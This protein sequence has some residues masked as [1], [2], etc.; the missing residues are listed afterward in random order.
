MEIKTDL[1]AVFENYCDRYNNILQHYYPAHNSTGFTERNQTT[2]FAAAMEKVCGNTLAWFEVP[3][4]DKKSQHFDAIIFNMETNE[5]FVVEAKRFSSFTGKAR[6]IASD[7]HRIMT[8]DNLYTI[9]QSFLQSHH[10]ESIMCYGIV[11]ADVWT[12]NSVKAALYDNWDGESFLDKYNAVFG[13]DKI[14]ESRLRDGIWQKS[15]LKFSSPHDWADKYRLLSV[16]FYAATVDDDEEGLGFYYK[17]LPD[18][19][20]GICCNPPVT[21]EEANYA[22]CLIQ[23]PEDDVKSFCKDV[24]Q[25]SKKLIDEGKSPVVRP[26]FLFDSVET[27]SSFTGYVKSKNLIDYAAL[28]YASSPYNAILITNSDVQELA[29]E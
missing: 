21:V 13:L 28:H 8:Y 18:S 22:V 9:T 25:L 15:M 7:I 19:S 17:F 23:V 14:T 12:E 29:E 1:Y 16:A 6:S 2:N 3:F 10:L 5:V 11:L 4:G 27:A 26:I 20:C 24:L